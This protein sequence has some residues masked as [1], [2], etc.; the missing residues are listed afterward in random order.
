LIT[1]LSTP[2]KSAGADL[3]LFLRKSS[4]YLKSEVNFPF[5]VMTA[6][7]TT[8]PSFSASFS[9]GLLASDLFLLII[10]K[11]LFIKDIKNVIFFSL[12]LFHMNYNVQKTKTSLYKIK[13]LLKFLLNF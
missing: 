6:P 10:L 1:F 3:V 13:K 11:K 9:K 8:G 5:E 2:E 12:Y 7:D 4:M